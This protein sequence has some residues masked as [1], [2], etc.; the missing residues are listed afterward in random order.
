M[1][2]LSTERLRLRHW[3]EDD[4][5]AF[6]DIYRRDEVSKWLGGSPEQRALATVDDAAVRLRRWIDHGAALSPPLGLWAIVPI[7]ATAQDHPI[8]TALLLPLHDANGPTDDI[9]V[10]WHLHPEHQGKGLATEAAAALLSAAAEAGL[11]EVLALT[12][13]DNVP[14]QAVAA[15]LGMVDEG[16][17]D[18][19]FGLTM[20]QF[21][22]VL[23]PV[24]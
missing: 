22:K 19:W 16:P 14:S 12:Y 2:L 15:R 21:R 1:E 10:G 5:D 8:G 3:R 17:T 6:F 24:S 7:P 18:R 23:G 4:V 11:A 9:E 13:L 20:R